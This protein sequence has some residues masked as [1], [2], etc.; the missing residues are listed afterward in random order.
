MQLNNSKANNLINKCAK[1][2]SGH[3]LRDRW[4]IGIQNSAHHCLSS[5]KLIS[6]PNELSPHRC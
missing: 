4:S 1:D 2:L 6:K 5:G 3:F